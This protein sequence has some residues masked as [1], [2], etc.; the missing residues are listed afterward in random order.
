MRINGRA[1]ESEKQ[2]MAGCSLS[3]QHHGACV[4]VCLL[5]YGCDN[6]LFETIKR[7]LIEDNTEKT[8]KWMGRMWLAVAVHILFYWDSFLLADTHLA[9]FVMRFACIHV[10]FPVPHGQL[11]RNI[12]RN[13]KHME[14]FN[15][16][17]SLANVCGFF[18]F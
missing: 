15:W 16:P 9:P 18:S 3:F 12:L 4:C 5:V 11:N 10:I 7:I 14:L 1:A 13:E 8:E 2:A 17:I 6:L